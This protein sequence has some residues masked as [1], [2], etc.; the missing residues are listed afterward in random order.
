MN[1]CSL[2]M[3]LIT[4]NLGHFLGKYKCNICSKVYKHKTSMYRHR[5]SH[6]TRCNICHNLYSKWQG[7]P[8][9]CHELQVFDYFKFYL[10]SFLKRLPHLLLYKGMLVF[11]SLNSQ[12]NL[13]VYIFRHGLLEHLKRVE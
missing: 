13:L 11:F 12:K 10:H 7:K 1:G 5:R 3:N 8:H 2:Q 4:S 9:K 6:K